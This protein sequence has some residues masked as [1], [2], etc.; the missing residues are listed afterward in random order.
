[1][2]TQP[3]PVEVVRDDRL[4]VEVSGTWTGARTWLERAR[5]MHEGAL[6]CQVMT[7]LELLKLQEDHPE[8]RGRPG[9]NSPNR[10][11]ISFTEQAEKETGLGRSSVFRLIEMAR[12]AL[13]RLRKLSGLR[14]FDP[15]SIAIGQLPEPQQEALTSAVKKITDGMTQTDFL[16][17]LGL[18][19]APQG[20][21]ATGGARHVG[22]QEK[23]TAEEKAKLY[24]QS[25]RAEFACA[26][27]AFS[28]SGARF[29]FLDDSEIRGQIEYLE[30]QILARRTWLSAPPASRNTAQVKAVLGEEPP[31]TSRK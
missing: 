1:M 2:T 26:V 16:A 29:T 10:G 4:P 3:T 27:K 24:A 31:T 21:G 11:L 6:F 12:A 8:T 15:T 20:S 22:P 18:V 14:D 25:A 5:L 13:P 17:E 19:K 23:L 30:R 9:K 7:G 28:I